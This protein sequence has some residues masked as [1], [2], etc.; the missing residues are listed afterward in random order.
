MLFKQIKKRDGRIVPFNVLKITD[1]INKAGVATGEFG[2][3]EAGRLSLLVV[4]FALSVRAEASMQV[5]SA[6]G[7]I[8][9]VEEI[10]D[11]VE[12]VLTIS[13]YR[14]TAKTY[15]IYR[16]QHKKIREISNKANVD[17]VD[18][19]LQK[20][21]W[22]VNENSN[23]SFSLQGLNNYVSSY[24]SK[25]YW[26]NKIYP[27]EIR[28][29]HI[30]GDLH[31]HD[32]NLLS[33]Y[34]VGWD[35]QDLLMK[36]FRGASGKVA[37]KPA[38]HFRTALGQIV[39]FFFTLQ[40]EAA[41]AQAF[42]NFDTF[43][44]PFIAFDKLSY[45]DVKQ[46]LQEFVFNLNVPTRVGF[47]TPFTNLTLD[48]KVPEYLAS[49]SVVTEGKLQS[50]VYGEFQR[51]MDLLNR[52]FMEVMTEGDA[53]GRVFTFP[54]PTYSITKDFDWDNENLKPLWKAT[55]K[56]GIPYF[57][58]FV[59]SD[60]RPEDARSMCCRLRLDTRELR[61]RGG[62]LFGANPLTG[63]I[64]VATINMPR[65]GYL[66]KDEDE[67]FARLGNLMELAKKSM[68]IKRKVLERY[69][70][71]N[72]YPYSKFYLAGIKERFGSYW[73]NH[74]STIGLI[75]MNEA[76]LNFFSQTIAS[77][78]GQEFS[79]RVLTFMKNKLLLFQDETGHF[80]NLEASPAEGTSYRLALTDKKRYSNI[81][82]AGDKKKPYYT[83]SSQ[84]PVNFTDDVFEAL[85]LQNKLQ[86][87]YTGGTVLHLFA[88][89]QI[90]D[91]RSVKVLLRTIFANYSLPY[92]TVTPTFSVCP[93]HGYLAGEHF[94]CPK[95][96]EEKI[97]KAEDEIEKLK[98]ELL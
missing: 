91:Y 1:A 6:K 71:G 5:C 93:V 4:N 73:E 94:Y 28:R 23:M 34:C 52:A 2:K 69:T 64:G 24:I 19:Y 53:D 57:A 8:P 9:T 26:L 46:A 22:K 77:G 30:D 25:I 92:I 14:K 65:I 82:T 15:I 66:S 39:N 63:S 70:D 74:F 3:D 29:A 54:I 41:G 45:R 50:A 96:R 33:V 58:N 79:N 68:E 97:L 11:I 90:S 47:Q 81:I 60:I 87:K 27:E 78:I 76:C 88:G 80:Y 36:G 61:R 55:A 43:L 40:G 49:Q 67:F 37:S 85:D 32:L 75:G 42:S 20:T 44:A 62:G 21:D 95:C 98:G 59:N 18:R 12:E 56:Y 10:Q 38:R 51:E 17:L 72:L 84:L 35:L 31:I 48:V 7:K 13:P 83:N 16:D 89:E 86:T